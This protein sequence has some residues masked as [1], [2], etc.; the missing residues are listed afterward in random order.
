M[1][2]VAE[3]LDHIRSQ[4]NLLGREYVDLSEAVGR[5]LAENIYA[6]MDLPPFN[7][8]QMDGYAVR[9]KDTMSAT[10]NAPVMLRVV[11]EAVAG[12]GWD[13]ELSAGEAVRIMTGAPVPRGADA[14]QQVELTSLIND[15][16]VLINQACTAHQNIVARASEVKKQTLV[17]TSGKRI[18]N[19]MIALFASFGYAQVSVSKRPRV[20]VL[21]TGAELVNVNEQ[22]RAEDQI[23]DSNSFSLAAYA[24]AAGARVERL[25]IAGDEPEQLARVI[26][27]ASARADVIV[28]SGGVSVGDY[29]FTKPVL[30]TLGAQIFFERVRLRPGKPT[31]FARLN[32][33][34]IF[35][36]PGNPVSSAV[37]FNLF[38]R[39]ALLLMQAA[40]D[41]SL[42]EDN[43][44]LS[45]PVKSARERVSYLPA[46]LHSDDAGRL[47]AEPLKWGGSSDF[48]SFARAD[49]LIIIPADCGIVEAD[50][51][52]R[53]LHLPD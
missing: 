1:I 51:L 49:S 12:R 46:I 53:V 11:G 16:Q 3:A 13:K 42:P 17:L 41:A 10:V 33:T 28:T 6:D 43:A 36:L 34:L 15:S 24:Q 30:K 23:R 50:A 20:A 31:V 37:T 9:A 18:T 40:T 26:A 39:F 5:V 4:V 25:P 52:V 22:P 8:S 7:R 27:E 14:V 47:I 38:A 32:E 29:D 35:G 45:R 44:L 21:A 48:V 19:R 2:S